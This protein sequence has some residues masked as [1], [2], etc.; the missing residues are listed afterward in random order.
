[1]DEWIDACIYSSMLCQS[2]RHHTG[3][4]R[5]GF[6]MRAGDAHHIRHSIRFIFILWKG[7]HFQNIHLTATNLCIDFSL[8][9]TSLKHTLSICNLHPSSTYIQTQPGSS[10]R[11]G[12]SV[13]CAAR[14]S[15]RRIRYLA[16]KETSRTDFLFG[17][18]ASN[19]F[20]DTILRWLVFI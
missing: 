8:P 4:I 2:N 17:K 19:R 1:M 11:M 3:W 6:S 13:F 14:A 10:G 18:H 12:V 15:L 16:R 7:W 9:E 5:L 20:N